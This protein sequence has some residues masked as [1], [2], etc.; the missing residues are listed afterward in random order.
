MIKCKVCGNDI[1]TKEED[2]LVIDHVPYY[3]FKFSEKTIKL[4]LVSCNFCGGVQLHDD[5]PLS[6]DYETVYRSMNVS[7]NYREQKKIQL[8]NFLDKYNLHKSQLI[9]VGCGDG[10]IIDIFYELGV[11]CEGVEANKNNWEV[12]NKKN[13]KVKLGN[14]YDIEKQ[15]DAFFSFYVLEHIPNPI[16]YVLA[17]YRILKP[18]G[19]GLIEVPNYDYIEQKG[20]WLEFTREHRIYYRKRTLEYLLLS[21]GFSIKSIEETSEGLC[22][23]IVVYKPKKNEGFKNIK[24]KILSDEEKFKNLIE[25]VNND[26]SIYGA[27]HYSQLLINLM[28]AKYGLKPKYIFDS[29]FTKCGNKIR[30]IE[31]FHKDDLLKFKDIKNI[32]IICGMYTDEVYNQ[33]VD[34]NENNKY[35]ENLIKWN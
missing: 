29:N 1:S 16:K 18:G 6:E 22:L 7:K 26:Y 17:L 5:I 15:Y 27:G 33:L 31:I 8:K 14:V 3:T 34:I 30:G 2:I 10:Q 28:D 12:C 32:I 13:Y 11:F 35:W 24:D 4:I 20:I 23:T 9:E 21:F 19:I 25:S